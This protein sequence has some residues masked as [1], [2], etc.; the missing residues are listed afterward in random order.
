MASSALKQI[1]DRYIFFSANI[2]I[3]LPSSHRKILRMET[4]L[5]IVEEAQSTWHNMYTR[6][7]VLAKIYKTELKRKHTVPLSPRFEAFRFH[8]T[9]SK[10][11][12]S[13]TLCSPLSVTLK[14]NKIFE[15]KWKLKN[16]IIFP[17]VFNFGYTINLQNTLLSPSPVHLRTILTTMRQLNLWMSEICLK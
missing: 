11:F 13:G 9:Y 1:N 8:I 17:V 12:G 7:L 16:R 10:P 2:Y 14:D 6:F 5:G 4:F 3:I 15:M